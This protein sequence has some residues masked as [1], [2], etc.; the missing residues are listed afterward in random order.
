M[1]NIIGLTRIFGK[2]VLEP[3]VGQI[4][5]ITDAQMRNGLAKLAEL[6]AQLELSED[7]R[8]NL[9]RFIRAGVEHPEDMR[10]LIKF[11]LSR[12]MEE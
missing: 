8:V 2:R 11:A 12:I 7:F 5:C 9:L 10:E 6:I 1:V 4:D 3:I